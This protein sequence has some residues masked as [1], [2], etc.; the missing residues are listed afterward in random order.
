MNDKERAE[1]L[2]HCTWVDEV[3]EDAPWVIDQA[4]IDKYMID[5]VAHD[6]IPYKSAE[7]DDV[8][9]F[10]K[11]Q[12][13]FLPTRRTD[14]ISTSDLIT[15]IVRD[16]D[17]YVRRNL[18]RGATAKELNV[19]F[20]KSQELK[21]REHVSEMRSAVVQNWHGTREELFSELDALKAELKQTLSVWED[22]S[23]DF[24]RGFAAKF[25][26]QNV[27]EKFFRRRQT[28][29]SPASNDSENTD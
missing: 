15:R 9:A 17:S 25:G 26:A 8:Y 24:V 11:Q 6:D 3:I 16:Y 2:R 20:L 23:S 5:Y 28:S 29:G 13:R 1:S 7:S 21:M 10:V 27:V 19:G 14:G 12:G 18:Q 22:K 4:F